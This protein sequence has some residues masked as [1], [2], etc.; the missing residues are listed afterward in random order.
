MLNLKSEIAT[1][2]YLR[3]RQTLKENAK[4]GLNGDRFKLQTTTL[5]AWRGGP[6]V[7]IKTSADCW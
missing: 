5:V 4:I 7:V 6:C 3:L 2:V 1:P